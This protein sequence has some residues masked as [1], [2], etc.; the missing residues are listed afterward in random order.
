MCASHIQLIFNTFKGGFMNT[1]K[2]AIVHFGK[3]KGHLG[4]VAQ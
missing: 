1:L 3:Y 4:G 2:I